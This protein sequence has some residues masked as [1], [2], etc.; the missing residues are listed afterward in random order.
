MDLREIKKL[1]EDLSGINDL[2]TRNKSRDHFVA[3]KVYFHLAR[4]SGYNNKE[5]AE[6]IGYTRY[7]ASKSASSYK[8][9]IIFDE[10]YKSLLRACIECIDGSYYKIPEPEESLP[11]ELT[12]KLLLLDENQ[13]KDF[14]QTRLI[15]YLKMQKLI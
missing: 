10:D 9:D 5:S 11:E 14:E 1:V 12:S 7:V 6:Y 13:I 3:R 2:R 8:S 4:N 15:P